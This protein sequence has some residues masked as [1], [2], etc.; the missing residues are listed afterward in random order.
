MGRVSQPSDVPSDPLAPPVALEIERTIPEPRL[1]VTGLAV[2]HHKHTDRHTVQTDAQR[3]ARSHF[4]GGA[5]EGSDAA[6]LD[7]QRNERVDLT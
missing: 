7:E 4:C 2:T 3:K 5:S 1:A 6:D